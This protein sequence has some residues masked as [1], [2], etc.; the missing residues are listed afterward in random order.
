MLLDPVELELAR[1]RLCAVAE[2]MGAVLAQAGLSPNIKERRDFSCAVFDAS[3]DMV[4]HA[5]H[6]PVHLGSTQLSV[7]AVLESIAME[8][9]DVA[10]VNDPYA[11]G[12]HLPDVTV[13]TPVFLPGSR[14]PIAYVANRAHHADIGG[15]S[16]GS[17]A[18]CEEIHQEGFRIPPLLL[19]R[20]WKPIRETLELFLAN[21][22][23]PSERRGDLAAQIAALETGVAR[24]LEV[25]QRMG[26]RRLVLAMRALQEYSERMIRSYIRKLPA[27]RWRARDRLDGDGFDSAP[28][29]I[30]VAVERRGSSLIVD[31]G[32]SSPQTRGPVNAN[33]AVTTSAVF[34]VVACLAGTDVPANAGMMKPV[35]IRAPRGTVVNCEFPAAVAGGNVETSQRIVDALLRALAP[36]LPERIPAASAGTMTNLALGGFD[37]VRGRHFAYYE[38]IAGGAGGGPQRRGASAVQTHMTNTRNTP[39]EVLESYYP[40]EVIHYRIRRG[41]GGKGRH[42]GGDGIDRAIR[43]LGQARMTLLA[44]RRATAPYGLAGGQPGRKGIDELVRAGRRQRLPAKTTERLKPGDVIR[45]RTPG[46]GGWGRPKRRRC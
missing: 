42:R 31:F 19:C 21:T 37:S 28:V 20:R 12:T 11:G 15:A 1:N 25:A 9:G 10:V 29:F 7:R 5:A 17:M 40:V 32:G 45:I 2:E 23:V 38:T 46:G 36:A 43:L 16:P 22:R 44:D 14:R 35:A 3:G 33:L 34:Y 8:A 30:Q 6:I 24:M 18:I 13:V 41:S 4:T 27:G 39:V 26:R